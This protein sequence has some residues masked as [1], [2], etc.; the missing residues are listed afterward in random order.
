[1]LAHQSCFAP[2]LDRLGGDEE[3]FIELAVVVLADAEP[4]RCQLVEAVKV[5]DF[6]TV[7][8]SG[9]RLKGMLS[10]FDDNSLTP[11]IQNLID[12]ARR[13]DRELTRIGLR[14][15]DPMMTTLLQRMKEAVDQASR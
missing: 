9:H 8:T 10:T 6:E 2:A 4:E 7:A 11:E 15:A 13:R 5:N 1:M 3:L 14:I 12:A